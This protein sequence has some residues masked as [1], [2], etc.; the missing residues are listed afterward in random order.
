MSLV[1][2]SNVNKEEFNEFT[3]KHASGTF[4]QHSNW[5]EVKKEWK[6]IYT[7]V[8]KNDVLVAAALII[9]RNIV[10]NYSLLYAPRGPVM[11]FADEELLVFYLEN[12]KKIAKREKAISFTIDPFIIND[13]FNMQ[14]IMRDLDKH[15]HKQ[16]DRLNV[17]NATGFEHTGYVSD[18]RESYQPRF[19]PIV[20]IDDNPYNSKTEAYKKYQRALKASVKIDRGQSD[21]VNRFDEL[22]NKTEEYKGISL[23]GSEYFT[24]ITDAYKDDSLITI[25]YIDVK[26]EL[27]SL[28]E[29]IERMSD[30]VNNHNMKEGR[31]NDYLNQIAAAKKDREF[32]LKEAGDKDKLDITG[33]LGLKNGTKSEILY[34]GMDRK[35]TKYYGSNV[36]YFDLFDWSKD[37]KLDFA[38]F[39][40]CSGTF[41]HGIDKYKATF[42]PTV[43]EFVG[44]FTFV[45][46]RLVNYLFKT[47]LK[48]RRGK[49]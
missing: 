30:S 49:R 46:K 39:G 41:D 25:A 6:P 21:L 26:A 19:T 24:R 12:L 27:D 14:L 48:I 10:L 8:Y 13:E 7:G 42:D 32:L 33:L 3:Y 9:K 43:I 36:N 5:S 45:N 22:I 20:T 34:A 17:F 2:S 16:Y 23:R 47:A 29:R 28:N 37:A 18:L 35:Y 15:E 44:E 1:F 4:F 38:S 11:D 40:G 31:R